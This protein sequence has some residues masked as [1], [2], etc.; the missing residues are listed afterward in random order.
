LGKIPLAP[1]DAPVVM[2]YLREIYQA[3]AQQAMVQALG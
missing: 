2:N 1:E 3:T